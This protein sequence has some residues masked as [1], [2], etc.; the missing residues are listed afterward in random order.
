MRRGSTLWLGRLTILDRP[1][2]AGVGGGRRQLVTSVSS[3]D[4]VTAV[5]REAVQEALKQAE[6]D[7]KIIIP[8]RRKIYSIKFFRV[9]FYLAGYTIF[10]QRGLSPGKVLESTV[11]R[12]P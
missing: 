8:V 11:V 5:S 1:G 10:S 4:T 6:I 2:V 3:N 12:G 9:H 7:F